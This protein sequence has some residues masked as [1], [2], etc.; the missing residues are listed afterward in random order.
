MLPG[1][2]AGREISKEEERGNCLAS[3]STNLA[4]HL[5]ELCE[6]RQSVPGDINARGCDCFEVV[7]DSERVCHNILMMLGARCG[8]YRDK[9]DIVVLTRCGKRM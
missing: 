8:E 5:R 3:S 2:V 9:Y 1:G 4:V 6:R 7:V